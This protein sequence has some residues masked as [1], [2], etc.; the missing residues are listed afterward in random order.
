MRTEKGHKIAILG[1]CMCLG[2][3]GCKEEVKETENIP[4]P[5][6]SEVI[7]D[8]PKDIEDKASLSYLINESEILTDIVSNNGNDDETAIDEKEYDKLDIDSSELDSI[9]TLDNKAEDIYLTR[10]Q[11]VDVLYNIMLSHNKLPDVTGYQL[12]YTDSDSVP[13]RYLNELCYVDYLKL[14]DFGEAINGYEYATE[15]E[16]TK[17]MEKLKKYLENYKEPEK[18]NSNDDNTNQE[19]TELEKQAEQTLKNRKETNLLGIESVAIYKNPKTLGEL[20]SNQNNI[21]RVNL[22]RLH[23]QDL[24]GTDCD[25]TP[26]N[27]RRINIEYL[28]LNQALLD[29]SMLSELELPGKIIGVTYVSDMSF[30]IHDDGY[31]K[32][33][34]CSLIE[35]ALTNSMMTYAVGIKDNNIVSKLEIKRE[36]G[37]EGITYESFVK[38]DI[39]SVGFVINK[40][41]LE[42][43]GTST[44]DNGLTYI[45]AITKIANK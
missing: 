14:I 6:N 41:N 21:N 38:K 5:I 1:L 43:A 37:F 24:L 18:D 12:T 17:S 26:M 36:F 11:L 30:G 9:N 25:G 15:E 8:I 34:Q 33:V 22:E 4:E 19:R 10:Y 20:E 7:V 32:V 44:D 13:A 3:F 28:E 35:D 16:V 40:G 42:N 45:I 23:Q 27:D 2:L 29:Y 31:R 39:D